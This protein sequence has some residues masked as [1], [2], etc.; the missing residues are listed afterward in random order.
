MKT[1]PFCVRAS[2]LVTVTLIA[3]PA[4]VAPIV[5]VVLAALLISSATEVAL[6]ISEVAVRRMSLPAV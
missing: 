1:P 2:R 3:L 4:P 5:P 6:D